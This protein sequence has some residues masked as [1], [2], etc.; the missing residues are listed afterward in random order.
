MTESMYEWFSAYKGRIIYCVLLL[1]LGLPLLRMVGYL[2]KKGLRKKISEQSIMLITKGVVYTGTTIVILM[3]LQKC[4]VNLGTLL[5]AAG[6]AGVAI[7]FASQTSL[8]NLISGLFLIGEKPFEVGDVLHAGSDHGVV[9]SV[10][11]LSVQLRTFNNQL[12]RIPNETLIKSSFTNVT[13]FPIRRMDIPIGVAY[14]EDTERVIRILKE[15]ADANPYCLDEPEP[16][17]I[18]KGFGD[19]ALEFMFGPWFSKTDYIALRNS[20]MTEIKKRFDAEG[21]EIPFP[22]RTL[23][24]G[25]VTKPFPVHVVPSPDTQ[26]GAV[27]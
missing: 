21:I 5:G 27:Q 2:I 24:A 18:F 7:G 23:Y 16:L 10:G 9:H 3:V 8:S 15:I 11:L 19:S 26:S 17:V 25:E 13:R 6:I 22:H 14:K 1:G 4:G 12:I 20:L